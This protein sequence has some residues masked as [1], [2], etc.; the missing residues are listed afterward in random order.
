MRERER[1]RERERD[2]SLS[3]PIKSILHPRVLRSHSMLRRI[4]VLIYHFDVQGDSA[5]GFGRHRG[6]KTVWK[7]NQPSFLYPLKNC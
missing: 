3:P 7:N 6:P 5:S 2:S 4:H 1:E